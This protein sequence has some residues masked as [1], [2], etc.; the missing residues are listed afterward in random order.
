MKCLPLT[1]T[2]SIVAKCIRNHM[3]VCCCTK[4]TVCSVGSTERSWAMA[5][6][7]HNVSD[8]DIIFS[9]MQWFVSQSFRFGWSQI[10]PWSITYINFFTMTVFTTPKTEKGR[11]QGR[12]IFSST[13]TVHPFMK[14]VISNQGFLDSLYQTFE[15]NY[16][17]LSQKL[18]WMCATVFS[19]ETSYGLQHWT[20][21][22]ITFRLG[23]NNVL[24]YTLRNFWW[25]VPMMWTIELLVIHIT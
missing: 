16:G 24:A 1:A 13:G 9:W 22:K 12:M 14:P 6:K 20:A 8:D 5:N 17:R 2:Y 19:H 4:Y 21:T 11:H 23:G 3:L 10:T 18:N 15:S 25:I 7:G